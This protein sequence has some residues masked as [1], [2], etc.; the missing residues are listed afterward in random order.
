MIVDD[1]GV[2]VLDSSSDD[3]S[4]GGGYGNAGGRSS[5]PQAA[6]KSAPAA[7]AYDS[8]EHAQYLVR[9]IMSSSDSSSSSDADSDAYDNRA[10]YD[11]SRAFPGKRKRSQ[12]ATKPTRKPKAKAALKPKLK[13]RSSSAG[14]HRR[15][16]RAAKRSKP[17][18][19]KA[20][21]RARYASPSD[22]ERDSD[23]SSRRS[24]SE[25]DS[26]S[27]DAEA[28][29][30]PA[31]RTTQAAKKQA[32]NS[33]SRPLS[34][35][36]AAPTKAK[37]AA[38]RT[39][40][41][42]A[43]ISMVSDSEDD[44]DT[45][46]SED[47]E[48]ER[49]QKKQRRTAAGKAARPAV[50]RSTS[51]SSHASVSA[52][53]AVEQITA[54]HAS[55]SEPRQLP[56]R[57]D[58]A[59]HQL[60]E[61][62]SFSELQAQRREL[63]Q[64]SLM[65]KRA[66]ERSGGGSAPSAPPAARKPPRL[67]SRKSAAPRSRVDEI[68][69][70]ERSGLDADKTRT[71]VVH[72]TAWR[73]LLLTRAPPNILSGGAA[74]LAQEDMND[75]VQRLI[76]EALPVLKD[77][78]ERRVKSIL[79]GTREQLRAYLQEHEKRRAQPLGFATPHLPA[80]DLTYSERS[81]LRQLFQHRRL[82]EPPLN[83]M[84][85]QVRYFV[86]H[87]ACEDDAS[88]PVVDRDAD[89][90]AVVAN[91]AADALSEQAMYPETVVQLSDD[92]PPLRKSWAY[93]GVRK[94]VHVADDPI[95]RYIPYLGENTRV[96]IDP[97]RYSSTTMDKSKRV[98]LIGSFKGS[99]LELKSVATSALDDELMEYLLRFVVSECGDSKNV[100]EALQQ[101]DKFSQ[102]YSDYYEIKKN[103]DAGRRLRRRV[104]GMQTL[105][106]D[107]R[108]DDSAECAAEIRQYLRA[109]GASC[110]FLQPRSE[111]K[112]LAS[113]LKPPIPFFE[114]NYQRFSRGGGLRKT[115][116]YSDATEWFRDL[117]CRRCYTY[118]CDEHGILQPTPLRR[119][120]PINPVVRKAGLALRNNPNG[121]VLD[122]TEADE[123][124]N[125]VAAGGVIE[126]TDSS[127][128]EEVNGA[129]EQEKT[130]SGSASASDDESSARRR[131]RRSQ[132]RISTLA[133]AS[134]KSQEKMQEKERRRQRRVEAKQLRQLTRTGDDSEY[135]DDSHLDTVRKSVSSASVGA[136]YCK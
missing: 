121:L 56:R 85:G 20:A 19:K 62:L 86:S 54:R 10:A 94:N 107:T 103:E 63:E 100:F 135:L 112:G 97:N 21:K 72:T 84:V 5:G 46:E 104:A 111:R 78:Q 60:T 38:A 127:S 8:D 36:A 28:S 101:S 34:A 53:V 25:A 24:R 110:W 73:R 1:D 106:N 48:A 9:E 79:R 15:A 132:T 65:H 18:A 98:E 33:K 134:L 49:R 131:S 29:R 119:T 50:K 93:I 95:L 64:L 91:E 117:F 120:D 51:Q 37:S 80:F 26:S 22:D 3:E 42:P 124:S 113:R 89:M 125:G 76:S 27:D 40:R 14:V 31:P 88:E 108:N 11:G 32:V 96:N 39:S 130:A 16:D 109:L 13:Q 123:S 118:D 61:K 2:I 133:S 81:D 68:E 75:R 59:F 70:R 7:S 17:I 4:D 90:D 114:S 69:R 6:R 74:H 128:D 66:A 44:D 105:M 87:N 71:P 52:A 82:R 92:I 55:G 67:E 43:F 12:H 41:P 77:C 115:K 58:H 57:T 136:A 102:P 126:L 83:S 99:V 122:V 35:S 30:S 129:A 47:S 45:R 116:V 23:D